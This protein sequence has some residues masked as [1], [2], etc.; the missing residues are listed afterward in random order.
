MNAVKSDLTED[1]QANLVAP[2]QAD[3]R[4][5]SL[6][7]VAFIVL[8]ALISLIP[9]LSVRFPPMTD[10]ANHYVRLWLL[11]GGI[12]RPHMADFYQI[13]WNVAWTNIAI[14]L[15]AFVLG[16]VAGIGIIGPLMLGLALLLPSL[17]VALLNR[18]L[19][20][21]FHWWQVLCFVLAW[22][23]VFLFGFLSFSISLGL[24]L[25]FA[26]ADEHLKSRNP[27]LVF[28]VRAVLSAIL[29]VAHPFGLLFYTALLAA[30]AFGPSI[31]PLR[32]RKMFFAAVLRVLVAVAP[33]FLPLVI[34]LL[35]GPSLPGQKNVS[36]FE[37]MY[38]DNPSLIRSFMMLLTYFRTY[39]I[40][41]DMI[42][43]L[44]L[45]VVVRETIRRNLMRL[46]WGLILASIV[47]GLLSLVMPTQVFD[48]GGIDVRL[49]CMMALAAAAGL[50]PDVRGRLQLI[51]LPVV[52]LVVASRTAFIEYVWL[53]RSADVASVERVLDHVEPG[54]AILPAQT[55]LDTAEF[56]KMPVGRSVGGMFPSFLHYPALASLERD[57]FM[58]YLFTAAGKQPLRVREPWR[59]IS[60]PEGAPVPSRLLDMDVADYLPYMADWKNRF[61]YILLL[62]ADMES[63]SYP[64]PTFDTVHIVADEGFARLYRIDHDA[65]H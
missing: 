39:D 49:P 1:E 44:L 34:F 23:S 53:Q 31:A 12:N 25:I 15:M 35:F 7:A 65:S 38:W 61:D 55:S 51:I 11:T 10:Y 9:V 4:R 32:Q 18:K 43:L 26:Y 46:H 52:F 40:R 16:K 54:A 58:P 21:G 42:Y 30:L 37:S 19:F 48:T 47:L 13:D 5:E 60:V 24:A 57:A 63:S 62:N 8:A 2:N 50:R 33:V 17:G 14:D 27:A 41:I 59:A 3:C 64:M 6:R 28:G 45:L 36:L 20:G 22:N 29:L 56:Q